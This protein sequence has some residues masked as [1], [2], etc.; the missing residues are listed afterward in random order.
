MRAA[1]GLLCALLALAPAG[2]EDAPPAQSLA[3]ITIDGTINPAV[4][5]FV[6]GS[7]E[8]AQHEECLPS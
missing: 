8:R 4:A 7:I 1:A 2:A 5:S 6:E 3:R